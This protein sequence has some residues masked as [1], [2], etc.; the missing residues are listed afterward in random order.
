MN[1]Q[2]ADEKLQGRCVNSRKLGNNTYLERHEGHLS[3]KFHETEII[4]FSPDDSVELSSGGWKTKTT[5]ERLNDY[6]P[7]NI[8]QDKGKWFVG[9]SWKEPYQSLF[10]DGMKIK[11]G[12]VL[13]PMLVNKEE[14]GLLK[15]INSYCKKMSAM[16]QLPMPNNGDCWYCSLKE[17]SSGKPLGDLTSDTNHLVSHLKEKYVHGSLILNAMKARGCTEFLLNMVFTNKGFRSY[18]IRA[19]RK[20]F[21]TKLGLCS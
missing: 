16:D 8:W 6:G 7:L 21:K 9:G 2:R 19:V 20:Y 5:K 13:K 18:A 12:I 4:K 3:I 10:Y 17:V 15:L 11:D 14:E 1:Y